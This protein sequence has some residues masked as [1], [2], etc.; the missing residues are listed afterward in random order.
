MSFWLPGFLEAV[1]SPTSQE[2]FISCQLWD[3]ASVLKECSVGL[4]TYCHT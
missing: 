3:S 2:G 1:L 4:G